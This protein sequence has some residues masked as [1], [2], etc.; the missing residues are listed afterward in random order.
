MDVK[1]KTA[2][3]FWCKKNNYEL[4]IFDEPSI[5]DTTK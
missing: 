2:W 4:V 5:E 3:E 1:F